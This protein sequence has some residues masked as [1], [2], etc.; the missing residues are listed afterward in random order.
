MPT[1][2]CCI[3]REKRVSK[4][5]TYGIFSNINVLTFSNIREDC[6]HLGW[7]AVSL[8]CNEQKAPSMV[9]VYRMQSV[10]E[11]FSPNYFLL[12]IYILKNSFRFIEN[13]YRYKNSIFSIFNISLYATFVTINKPLFIHYY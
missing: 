7:A 10:I 3:A 11:I 8:S 2:A 5:R 4:L 6:I 12:I 13:V 1:S 9:L